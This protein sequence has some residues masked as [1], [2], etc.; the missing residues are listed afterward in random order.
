MKS[1]RWTILF[2][3]VVI[4]FS[5]WTYFDYQKAQER[6]SEGEKE[7]LILKVPSEE[8]QSLQFHSPMG[9]VEVKRNEKSWQLLAPIQDRGDVEVI[10]HLLRA[11]AGEKTL[12]LIAE[13]DDVD[14]QVYG[15][16]HPEYV[17]EMEVQAKDEASPKKEVLK[18]GSVKAYDSNLYL[19]RNKENKIYLVS[20]GWKEHL[21]KTSFDLRDKTIVRDPDLTLDNLISMHLEQNAPSFPKKIILDKNGESWKYN[22]NEEPFL[23]LSSEHIKSYLEHLK[24]LRAEEILSEGGSLSG[25]NLKFNFAHPLL[26]LAFK[27]SSGRM[28]EFDF[29][30]SVGR[31][32]EAQ[33]NKAE[34]LDIAVRDRDSGRVFKIS[35]SSVGYLKRKIENFY[36]RHYP[37]RFSTEGAAR[38]VLKTT[39]NEIA[40]KLIGQKWVDE[41]H[42]GMP[43]T[44]THDASEQIIEALSQ[45][46]KIEAVRFFAKGDKI[47]H[48]KHSWSK[49]DVFDSAGKVLVSMEWSELVHE[50][51]DPSRPEASYYL[52]K[53]NLDS[54]YFGVPSGSLDGIK[55]FRA[56]GE[57]NDSEKAVSEP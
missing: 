28:L 40:L 51:E 23:P 45:I 5:L 56:Q 38:I 2:G 30:A 29:A 54:H 37:F 9:T 1:F 19:Q 57:M 6:E 34:S 21:K 16:D 24:S 33:K 18:I 41:K 8:I 44:D 31:N 13:G 43:S 36:D 11:M 15:L 22:G 39:K 53:T 52:L 32:K 4:T 49:F 26:K 46:K 48:Q 25:K 7:A 55:L 42:E 14:L 50:K 17:V 3:L 20:S 27:L 47:L 12:E 35:E 10:D